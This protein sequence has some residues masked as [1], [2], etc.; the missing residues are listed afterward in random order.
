[1]TFVVLWFAVAGLLLGGAI[2][3]R[4][5]KKPWWVSIVLAVLAAAALWFAFV[6]IEAAEALAR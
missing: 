6:N 1:M 5:Q 2:S 3:F 4:T